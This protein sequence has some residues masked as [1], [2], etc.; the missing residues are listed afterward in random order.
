MIST[1]IK[2]QQRRRLLNKLDDFDQNVFNGNSLSSEGQ[3]VEVNV[4]LTDPQI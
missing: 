3:F 4:S 1:E 2:K